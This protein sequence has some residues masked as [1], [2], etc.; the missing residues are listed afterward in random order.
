MS[1]D[2]DVEKR[3]DYGNAYII[4]GVQIASGTPTN[5]QFLVYNAS[6]NQWEY[7]PATI[8]GI[9]VQSGTPLNGQ[10]LQYD[11]GAN[12]WKFI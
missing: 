9:P 10:T 11:Q 8:A 6:I 12:E 5:G 3:F 2:F 7:G 4:S 1:N